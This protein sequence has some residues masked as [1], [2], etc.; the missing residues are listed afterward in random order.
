MLAST[1]E[2][3]MRPNK[4]VPATA[5]IGPC[6]RSQHLDTREW[7]IARQSIYIRKILSFALVGAGA[8]ARAAL[9][10]GNK[11][12]ATIISSCTFI[13]V[14]IRRGKDS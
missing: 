4:L 14:K 5:F 1:I 2:P 8:L 9:N 3:A 13:A 11:M 10:S 7:I 6:L 12:N